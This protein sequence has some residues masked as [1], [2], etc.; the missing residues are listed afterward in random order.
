M[1]HRVGA[2]YQAH[3]AGLHPTPEGRVGALSDDL[4]T[5]LVMRGADLIEH[6]W[7]VIEILL[8]LLSRRDD[9]LEDGDEPMHWDLGQV[10][11]ARDVGRDVVAWMEGLAQRAGIPTYTRYMAMRPIV[12]QLSEADSEAFRTIGYTIGGMMIF[13]GN[14]VDGKQTIN[15]ARGFNPRIADRLDL[16]VECIRRHYRSEASPLSEML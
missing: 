14:R 11:A 2:E 8:A 6:V 9:L 10:V 5:R 16:T 12:A 13:P 15:G 1:T 3:S 4:Q 7:R